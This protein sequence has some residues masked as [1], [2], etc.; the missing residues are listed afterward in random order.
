MNGIKREL[1]EIRMLILP[2]L[3][4]LGSYVLAQCYLKLAPSKRKH[5]LEQ[6]HDH[7]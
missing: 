2:L 3:Q 1:K 5:L 4:H 6:S 7:C